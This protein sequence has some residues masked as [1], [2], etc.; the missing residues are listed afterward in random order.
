MLTFPETRALALTITNLQSVLAML[1]LE[2]VAGDMKNPMVALSKL[3]NAA[4]CCSLGTAV[5]NCLPHHLRV[6]YC[7]V[8]I[9]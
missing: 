8:L 9:A 2:M 4:R 7:A 3:I 6:R 5:Y 1:P